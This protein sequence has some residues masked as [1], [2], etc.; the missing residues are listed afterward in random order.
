[1]FSHNSSLDSNMKITISRVKKQ[2]IIVIIDDITNVTVD[3]IKDAIMDL[4]EVPD[5]EH[6]WLDVVPD[7]DDSFRISV[8]QTDGVTDRVSDLLDECI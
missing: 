7:G 1:M 6:L 8:I 2:E 4:V 5:D 3:N